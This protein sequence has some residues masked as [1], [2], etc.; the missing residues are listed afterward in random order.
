MRVAIDDER[1]RTVTIRTITGAIGLL[2]IDI[3]GECTALRGNGN[4]VGLIVASMD[5]RASVRGDQGRAAVVR[6][7][8]KGGRA[9]L[10][11]TI[12][13]KIIGGAID[14]KEDG[15]TISL[16]NLELYF[17]DEVSVIDVLGVARIE[18]PS[19]F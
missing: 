4:Q 8:K 19:I 16:H 11:H 14:A 17:K 15:T 13:V 3:H 2:V 6:V 5:G 7:Q 12:E 10:A 1:Y 18:I 9:I